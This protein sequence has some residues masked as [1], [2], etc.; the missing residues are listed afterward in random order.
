MKKTYDITPECPF[1]FDGIEV[2][3]DGIHYAVTR[4]IG[5]YNTVTVLSPDGMAG[6]VD[7]GL[8]SE[9]HWS[10]LGRALPDDDTL[11]LAFIRTVRD[12]FPGLRKEAS[13]SERAAHTA[14]PCHISPCAKRYVSGME[15]TL[16]STIKLHLYQVT[17]KNGIF[18][19]VMGTKPHAPCYIDVTPG[20]DGS[21]SDLSPLFV[22][23]RDV[24]KALI[25]WTRHLF[26][27]HTCLTDDRIRCVKD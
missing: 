9:G 20:S 8:T 3:A 7:L 12:L 5:D 26:G 6:Y 21:N 27:L 1:F 13:E 2:V 11:R 22:K 4:R 14:F 23:N 25:S 19:E 16:N 24:M 18:I 17:A 15:V 10:D